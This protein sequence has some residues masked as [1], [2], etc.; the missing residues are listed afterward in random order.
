MNRRH[1]LA[2]VPA[3]VVAAQLAPTA[4]AAGSK[5]GVML[6]NRIGPSTSELYIANADGTNERKFL[7]AS[8][9][10]YHAGFSP[11]GQWVTFTS[12]RGGLGQADIYRARVDG[13]GI[14]RLTRSPH[15]DDAG[16]LSPDG[17][18][19]AFS[20]TRD[21]LKSNIC[22]LDLKTGKVRNLT[23]QPSVQGD[24]E[25]P[26]GYFKPSWSPD[27]QWIAFS[28]DRNTNWRG[29]DNGAGWE[30][31]QELSIYVIKPDGTGFRHV[32]T[33][34]TF[35]LGTPRWSPDGKRIAYYELATEDTWGARRPER[36][37]NVVSQIVSVAVD[38]SDRMEHT[39]GP[40]L[41]IFPQYLAADN[42][43][44]LQK[45]GPN[46]G[47]AYSSGNPNIK[48]AMRSPTWS[49]DG[50]SM[51]YEKVS[52]KP[53]DNYTPLYS[54]DAHWD[55]RAMDVFPALSRDGKLV[56]TDKAVD[57]SVV[58]MDPDGSNRKV[59]FA[60][61]TSGLDPQLVAH[62]LAGAFQPA[63]SPDSQWVA[64]GLG[65]WFQMRKTGGAKIMRVR[66]DGTGAEALTDGTKNEGFPSY[67]ADGKQLVYR[68]W[69]DDEKGLRILNIADRKIT[70][71]TTEAD[72]LPQWSPDG[73]R[74][75]FTRSVDVVNFDIFTI[76]PDGTGLTRLTTSPAND[77][78]AVWSADGKQ[79]LWN[80]G[81]YGF[82]DEAA[83]YD[84]TFQPYGQ[85]WGMNADGSNKHMITDSPWEDSMPLYLPN[86]VWAHH[87]PN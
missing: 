8:V 11:D 15:V 4:F 75:L 5:R 53:R 44:Y 87:N 21:T 33:K 35:C 76:R 1:F 64:F 6:M 29:H 63:W 54:W 84:N 51:I 49:P 41:K 13:S 36:V 31:T 57:S 47:L 23:N 56:F 70:V 45:G 26:D 50:K 7:D 66:R 2:S 83:L 65:Q 27:G 85:D 30:H 86:A 80:S 37:A 39:S 69:S 58:I 14:Q 25:K 18:K 67:S 72:N 77:G 48:G 59:I 3:A 9:F 74:I 42:I 81:A 12:E 34:P 79:I 19:L 20:S 73:R 28:S 78:H 60:T 16:V 17:T 62:G 43:A 10:D 38:G 52:Y 46:E 24:A 22:V 55:Y 82:R 32:A 68:I 61:A 40:G 71:L